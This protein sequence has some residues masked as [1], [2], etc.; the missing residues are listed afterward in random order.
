MPIAAISEPMSTPDVNPASPA[1]SDSGTGVLAFPASVSQQ[2]FWYLELL[3]GTVTAFNVPLRFLITGPLDISLFN[4]ALNAVVERHESLRTCFGEEDGELLQFVSPEIIVRMPVLDISHLPAD[5]IKE[6]ADRLGSIE[7]HRPFDLSKAP[8]LRAEILRLGPDRHIFHFTV[9]H[10]LFD[11]MSMTIFTAELSEFYQA[12]FENRAPKIEP[13]AI[14]YGDYSVWQKE[15][16]EGPKVNEQLNYWKK[17]L[18]GMKEVALPTDF[19]RPSVKSWKGD[20]TSTLLPKELSEKLQSIAATKGATLCHV[21]LAAFMMLLNR[22]SG[23]LDVAVGAPVVGRTGGDL[24]PLIGVFINTVILRSDLSGNPTFFDYLTQIRN[25]SLESLENQE[26]PFEK[27]VH[28]LRPERDPSR[29]PLFQVNFNHHRSFTTTEY[30]GGCELTTV[31]SRSPGA[32][33]DLHL[34]VVEREEGWRAALDFCTELFTRESANRM[35]VHFKTL[36]ENIAAHP[37]KQI[38]DFEILPLPNASFH[39]LDDQGK[40]VP[41]G[42]TGELC[43]AADEPVTPADA[44]DG[45]AIEHPEFGKLI[46]TGDIC[47]RAPDGKVDFIG[48]K[49]YAAAPRENKP[50]QKP[51]RRPM[52]TVEPSGSTEAQLRTIWEDLLGISDIGRDDDFFALGGHSL[53]SLR[54]FS[55]IHREFGKTLPLATLLKHPTIASLASQIDLPQEAPIPVAVIENARP[56]AKFLPKSSSPAKSN[57]ITLTE[58]DGETP[59]FCIHGGDGG[60][61]FYRGLANLMPPEI[62]FHAIE[63]LEL[64]N[65]GSIVETSIEET[66]TSYLRDILSLQQVGP[67]RLAGYSFGGVVAH[68]IACQ[69]IEQGHKVEFLGMFDTDNPTAPIRNYSLSERLGVFWRR[70]SHIPFGARLGLV[71][72]RICE[73]VKTNRRIKAELHAAK[74][75]GPAEAYS[76]MRRV[77]VRE[78]NWRAMQAYMPRPFAG[79]ITLFKSTHVSDKYERL[80]D[81][82]W[83]SSATG[84]DVVPV[85]GEHLALFASENVD[86][87]AKVVTDALK[88]TKHPEA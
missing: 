44:S 56:V 60:V 83:S 73:G 85:E 37:E 10:A 16:L 24:E 61:I 11:G 36:L 53:M 68:E 7:A 63:S 72:Q 88:P 20:I 31:P 22:Y 14:Q 15:F 8:L 65:S 52:A 21:H 76:D 77:Q 17:Q 2:M 49:G 4:K 87:L 18:S 40:P 79:R 3:Q 9:H 62:P 38:A 54:M 27:L 41:D 5:R 67:F 70:N 32:I 12:F 25:N 46:C 75:T 69:L 35:L 29:N 66:A 6:E 55:R 42:M 30:F 51:E 57:I 74:T 1:V 78:E 50:E 80:D 47:R 43:L 26:L 33:F 82:G 28:E 86:N 71:R 58:G 23:D 48:R 64:S 81:Y 39:L 34:F 13:L 84:L 45:R 59:L 19:P